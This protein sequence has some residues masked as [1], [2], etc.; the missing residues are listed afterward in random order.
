M[1]QR[2][3]RHRSSKPSATRFCIQPAQR[4]KSQ[5]KSLLERHELLCEVPGFLAHGKTN[6][7]EG[8]FLVPSSVVSLSRSSLLWLS[9]WSPS[10]GGRGDRV[11]TAQQHQP[12][13]SAALPS[14][15]S[16][17][18]SPSQTL[19]SKTTKLKNIDAAA[20][21]A[22]KCP[23]IL[24]GMNFFASPT[25]MNGGTIANILQSMAYGR[26]TSRTKHQSGD[27]WAG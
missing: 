5:R 19:G 4:K 15:L 2:D 6:G 10:P 24:H 18:L 26:R 23:L 22:Q 27:R 17:S 25:R 8:S 14:S 11:S 21:T 16:L 7:V 3:N 12:I 13:Q 1:A 20:S 9:L